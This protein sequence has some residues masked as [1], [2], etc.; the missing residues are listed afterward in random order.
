M[1]ENTTIQTPTHR[2]HSL[3]HFDLHFTLHR[4]TQRLKFTL[5]PNQDIIAEGASVQYLGP[6]GE[7]VR[8]ELIDR[9]AHKIYKGHAWLEEHDGQWANVGWARI[10]IKRDGLKPLFEG[11]FTLGRDHHHVQLRS[12]YMSTKHELDPVAED[13]GDEYMTVFRD[14]DIGQRPQSDH[15]ELKRSAGPERSCRSDQLNFNADS[16][17][18]VLKG[19]P[20]FGVQLA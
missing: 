18:T 16:F 12:H 2:V 19:T 10:M 14:S 13:A 3:S 11:A 1:V 20:D 9:H 4:A 8:S 6:D 7:P 17:Q 5:E 15:T